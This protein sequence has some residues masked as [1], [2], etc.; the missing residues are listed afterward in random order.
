MQ[1]L[2]WLTGEYTR[3]DRR[4]A[5]P[6][7]YIPNNPFFLIPGQNGWLSGT[8]AW[9]VGVRWSTVD[10]MELKRVKH[11][12]EKEHRRAGER[13]DLK[14]G[15]G[16]I[17]DIEFYVQYLQLIAG[18]QHPEV[19]VGPTLE[20][21]RRLAAAR[22]LLAGEESQLSLSYRF[23]R[24]VEHRL[25]LR[26]LTP[27]VVLPEDPREVDSL[28]RGLGFEGARRGERL[29][30]VL[31]GH[32]RRVRAILERIY[33]TPGYLHLDEREE[34][35]A[36]LVTERTPRERVREI[37]ARYGFQDLDR[38]CQNLRLLAV[39]PAGRILPHAERRAFLGF[40][41]PLLEVLRDS[42]DPDR[43]LD[44]LESFASASGNRVSFLR[45][46]A[47]RRAHLERL[48][49]LLAASNLA[50]QILVRHPEYF[51]Y[52]ARGHH[53]EAERSASELKDELA[54]R[55]AEA[56]AGQSAGEV[57]RRFRQRETVRIAYRD[58]GGLGDPLQISRELSALAEA[59]LGV[60]VASS[61]LGAPDSPIVLALGKL[62]SRQM[63]YASDL[64]LV[65]LYDDA[66]EDANAEDRVRFAR[67]EDSRV[68]RI[69]ELLAGVTA[70][71]V[72]YRVDLRLRPEGA[73]G[74][75]ARSW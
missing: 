27:D 21:I 50:R 5:A 47:S 51:D 71:G 36:Q 63:H 16:G 53:L 1:A 52:L 59:C 34:E 18:S 75:L 60:A 15:W 8:G 74:L 49:N 29:R 69:L 20:A 28:A 2:Y 6:D 14:Q 40:A 72:A 32:R 67:L 23:L 65:F 68:E 41:A 48:V 66:S 38:A 25:Q 31:A 24:T 3:W 26:A 61:A 19:R 70:E 73:S 62:G 64:D 43:A 55:V 9:Q 56:P 37:L 22:A 54:G 33:L 4:A 42:I 46:L 10:G 58:L 45:S 57:V 17:R 44:N 30:A 13:F 11:R 12:S 39:G 35:L 7:R